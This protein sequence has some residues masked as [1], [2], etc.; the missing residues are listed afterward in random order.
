MTTEFNFQRVYRPLQPFFQPREVTVNS[1]E[2]NPEFISRIIPKVEWPALFKAA[3]SVSVLIL[4]LLKSLIYSIQNY[5]NILLR[6]TLSD[7]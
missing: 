6:L 7:K 1:I 2:F 5:S 4:V 3:E